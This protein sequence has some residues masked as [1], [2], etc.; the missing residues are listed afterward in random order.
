MTDLNTL[1]DP[2][3]GWQLKYARAINDYGQIVGSG[4]NPSGYEHAY[5]LTPV[6]EPSTF[7][8][9]GMGAVGLL[10]WATRRRRCVR[11]PLRNVALVWLLLGTPVLGDVPD[12]VNNVP[13]IDGRTAFAAADATFAS[14]Q[15]FT[16]GIGGYLSRIELDIL[17][18]PQTTQNL[19]VGIRPTTSGHKPVEADSSALAV[20]YLPASSVPLP[21]PIGTPYTP[22]WTSVDFGQFGIPVS[23]G[24][25]VA[26]TLQSAEPHISLTNGYAWRT[27]LQG[28]DSY[29]GG[30][31]F[32]RD[33][34][35]AN[36]WNAGTGAAAYDAAFR[37][38]VN[39]VPEPSTFVLLGMGAAGLLG[40]A[41]RRRKRTTA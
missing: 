19:L 26:I 40:F 6:P 25:E 31:K 24:Q 29:A 39:A 22:Q 8:L 3:S 7:V 14:A 10:G 27:T 11:Q 9:L 28:N 35:N 33:H 21:P 41:W 20:V 37:T 32:V 4:F 16:V 1:I 5:L 17:R 13:I 12:Q 34:A 38:Y 30:A 23:A 18:Y 2:A 36:V 15:T